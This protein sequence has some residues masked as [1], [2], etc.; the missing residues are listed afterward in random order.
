MLKGRNHSEIQHAQDDEGSRKAEESEKELSFDESHF[1]QSSPSLSGDDLDLPEHNHNNNRNDFSDSDDL[2]TAVLATSSPRSNI[3]SENNSNLASNQYI[4]YRQR[5][6]QYQQQQ[7]LR[8]L[9]LQYQQQPRHYQQQRTQTQQQD[10]NQYQY[11]LPSSP[12]SPTSFNV[13]QIDDCLNNVTGFK[14][15]LDQL[16]ADA[17]T[18][19]SDESA[20]ADE[21]EDYSFEPTRIFSES[22]QSHHSRHITT[23][24]PTTNRN[25]VIFYQTEIPSML[26]DEIETG[27]EIDGYNYASGDDDELD[28][29]G[30]ITSVVLANETRSENI[31]DDVYNGKDEDNNENRNDSLLNLDATELSALDD[32]DDGAFAAGAEESLLEKNREENAHRLQL[33]EGETEVFNHPLEDMLQEAMLEIEQ[34]KA[35]NAELIR[36]NTLYL[37]EIAELNHGLETQSK[38][39]ARVI[40]N[41]KET[42]F[43]AKSALQT[44]ITDLET[45]LQTIK[46]SAMQI[47][48]IRETLQHE[49]DLDILNLRVELMSDKE[50]QLKALKSQM[51]TER[52]RMEQ[53]M[54]ALVQAFEAERAEF[55]AVRRTLETDVKMVPIMARKEAEEE[56]RSIRMLL[57]EEN[58][59]AKKEFAEVAEE[60]DCAKK[61]LA[62]ANVPVFAGSVAKDSLMQ[63]RSSNGSWKHREPDNSQ[64][65]A[66]TD[67]GCQADFWSDYLDLKEGVMELRSLFGLD[68]EWSVGQSSEIKDII[69][70][71]INDMELKHDAQAHELMERAAHIGELCETIS[72]LTKENKYWEETHST[73]IQNL[74]N[75]HENSLSS[76]KESFGHQIA[77]LTEKINQ[78]IN[79][80]DCKSW[81][82]LEARL[83]Y[84][85][86]VF[87]EE[88]QSQAD[89]NQK[90]FLE[91]VK[92]T[93]ELEKSNMTAFFERTLE[94]ETLRLKQ[95]HEQGIKSVA[96]EIKAQYSRAYDSA[97]KKLKNEY[98]NLEE[99]CIEKFKIN[100][101]SV[102]REKE[103]RN[104]LQNQEAYIESLEQ[105]HAENIQRIKLEFEGLVKRIKEEARTHY[106]AQLR[107]ALDKMKQRY[108]ESLRAGITH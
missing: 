10:A 36:E 52:A 102:S 21:G 24:S 89:N 82:D 83:P 61:Q 68:S 30:A 64:R 18:G 34:L 86:A 54:H 17:D 8:Q 76:L 71:Y 42:E 63:S 87:R 107:N 65:R 40:E 67:V 59:P 6:L 103:W 35:E 25:S 105:I 75:S 104:I 39:H 1:A 85:F 58:T 31:D 66:M 88:V 33:Q 26:G 90:I 28:Q 46:S 43:S 2:H 55:E 98:V 79:P 32:E 57:G 80:D 4:E 15:Q 20:A 62:E 27:D 29:I 78:M 77:I 69:A 9:Q 37:G 11:Q 13:A 72:R 14:E 100:S 60:L 5:Q 95:N 23:V 12:R 49:K 22:N 96:S 92:K 45:D 19:D 16:D 97:V 84:L 93:V 106:S 7:H 74:Q 38:S 91:R 41:L 70:G 108:V 94:S 73:T 53:E 44:R 3:T 50:R 99:K 51:D 56:I 81:H 47:S 101:A 48:T